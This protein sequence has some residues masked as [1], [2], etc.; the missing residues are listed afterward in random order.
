MYSTCRT[1]GGPHR[2]LTVGST[3]EL[4][5][6]PEARI[7]SNC[8]DVGI[9]HC[10]GRVWIVG[11][12][13]NAKTTTSLA[14]HYDGRSWRNVKVTA[15]AGLDR[16]APDGRGGVWSTVRDRQKPAGQALHPALHP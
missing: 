16:V 3:V 13:R 5:M 14:L 1:R 8:S 9:W 15:A 12:V 4:H 11:G 7:D 2:I 6:V 10:Q